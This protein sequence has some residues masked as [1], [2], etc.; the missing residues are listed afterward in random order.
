MCQV[1]S[2]IMTNVRRDI[3]YSPFL[4]VDRRSQVKLSK[5]KKNDRIFLYEY[6]YIYIYTQHNIVGIFLYETNIITI[7]GLKILFHTQDIQGSTEFD[8]FFF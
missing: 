3:S 7:K 6:I 4:Q 8:P 1:I 5:K 2:Y